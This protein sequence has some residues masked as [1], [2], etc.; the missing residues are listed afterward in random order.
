MSYIFMDESWCLWQNLENK[1]TS[2]Y[3]LVTFLF[4]ENKNLIEKIPKKVFKLFSK[5]Q[6]KIRKWWVLHCNKEDKKTK[7]KLLNLVSD[8]KD[9][10]KVFSI[11]LDKNDFYLSLKKEKIAIYNIIVNKLLSRIYTKKII[12][13]KNINFYASKRETNKF[14]NKEFKN[15]LELEIKKNHW[16]NINVIIKSHYEDKSLQVVDFIS[17]AIF[18]KYEFNDDNYYN[19]IKKNIVEEDYMY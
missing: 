12:N 2:R 14:L 18:R 3:F 4:C 1:W 7:V 8:N 13:I 10:I 15:F 5:K 19:I 17:W 9:N 6:I 11:I 16:K